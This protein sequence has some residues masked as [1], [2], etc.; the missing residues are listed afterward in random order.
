MHDAGRMK[1]I[2]MSWTD[3]LR[4]T[5][6][7]ARAERTAVAR[8]I[9]V[10]LPWNWNPH[11]VWLARARKARAGAAQSMMHGSWAASIWSDSART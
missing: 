1:H 3:T 5:A 7:G 10:D 9:G 2:P 4:A 6:L 11:D 8:R